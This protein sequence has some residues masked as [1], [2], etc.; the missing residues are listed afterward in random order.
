[1]TGGAGTGAVGSDIMFCA[2]DLGPVRHHVAVT[3]KLT[4]V[5]GEVVRPD[6]DRMSE[7]TMAGPLVGVAVQAGDLVPFNPF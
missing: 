1:M 2:F 4:R 5:I 6:F 7:I 3:A